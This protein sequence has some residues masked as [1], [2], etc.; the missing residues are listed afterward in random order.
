[1]THKT[2]ITDNNQH[3]FM[4][5][6]EVNFDN[7]FA[8][9]FAH[10]NGGNFLTHSSA[11]YYIYFPDA[12]D[13]GLV[14]G[15]RLKPAEQIF[16]ATTERAMAATISYLVKINTEKNRVYFSQYDSEGNVTGFS[17]KGEKLV[18]FNLKSQA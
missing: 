10:N 14:A 18:Y 17:T 12:F 1:M 4:P 5:H 15:E 2:E 8:G 11:T 13:R 16:R 7:E 9:N 3:R 6:F